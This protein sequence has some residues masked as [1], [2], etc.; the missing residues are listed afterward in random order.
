MK[1]LRLSHAIPSGPEIIIDLFAGGGGASQ[2]P[3]IEEALVRVN[4][5]DLARARVVELGCLGN[6]GRHES[7]GCACVGWCLP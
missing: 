3:P 6:T 7:S 4:C 5:L 2:S 1:T